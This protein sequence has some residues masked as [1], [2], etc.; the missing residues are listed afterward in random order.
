MNRY[1]TFVENVH[2]KI[3][4]QNII[5]HYSLPDTK[6]IHD[7]KKCKF[8]SLCDDLK[9][10]VVN[11]SEKLRKMEYLM[12]KNPDIVVERHHRLLRKGK[13]I[14]GRFG[15]HTDKEGPI[16]GDCYSILY[17]YR[18]DNFI[19]KGELNFYNHECH[20]TPKE[21]FFPES[22]DIIAFGNDV[23]HCPGNFSTEHHETVTR[24]LLSIFIK[25]E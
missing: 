18:I 8:E 17:Y 11:G 13:K 25:L 9:Y 12:E 15:V 10:I 5:R 3:D 20:R 24:G 22:G 4:P 21:S 14:P 7:W 16:G 6:E 23:Y 19:D 1:F 2:E